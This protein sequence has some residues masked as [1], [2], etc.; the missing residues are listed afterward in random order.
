M[1]DPDYPPKYS[2]FTGLVE[3]DGE[4]FKITMGAGYAKTYDMETDRIMSPSGFLDFL[5]QIHSKDWIT[6]QHLKDV[7][8]AYE[9]WCLAEHGKYP[10]DFLQVTH[11]MNR[12]LDAP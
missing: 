11:G 4:A 9:K 12:G 8:D 5:L 10:Q 2:E 3:Y 1:I 7:L 6:G